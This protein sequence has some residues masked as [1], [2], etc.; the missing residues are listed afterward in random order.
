MINAIRIFD[1]TAENLFAFDAVGNVLWPS[2]DDETQRIIRGA[3][4]RQ[5][6]EVSV[7]SEH[8]VTEFSLSRSSTGKV[9]CIS[10]GFALYGKLYAHLT[11]RG[12][13]SGVGEDIGNY[14]DVEVVVVHRQQLTAELLEALY[15]KDRISAPG[16]LVAVDERDCY[17][18]VLAH[19]VYA[20]PARLSEEPLRLFELYPISKYSP[21]PR[22]VSVTIL[23]NTSSRES[24]VDAVT[25]RADVMSVFSH[26]DGVDA[27]FGNNVT[28]CSASANMSRTVTSDAPYCARTR[29]CFRFHKSVADALKDPRLVSVER[30]GARVLVLAVCAGALTS[31]SPIEFSWGFLPLVSRLTNVGAIATPWRIFVGHPSVLRKALDMLY[32]GGSIGEATER[33]NKS[34]HA[35]STGFR[36]AIF[37]DPR[38][39]GVLSPTDRSTTE[40]EPIRNTSNDSVKLVRLDIRNFFMIKLA[41]MRHLQHCHPQL[42][43]QTELVISLCNRL[44]AALASGVSDK[45]LRGDAS[46][47]QKL[48][49]DLVLRTRL[50]HYWL[51]LAMDAG[52]FDGG[53]C[54][55]CNS[56]LQERRFTFPETAADGRYLHICP[57]CGVVADGQIGVHLVTVVVDAGWIVA[58]GLEM[59][60]RN[61][62]ATLQITSVNSQISQRHAWPKD[63]SGML[64]AK[65]E[66]PAIDPA[67]GP[68]NV[69][70]GVSEDFRILVI[71]QPIRE[72]DYLGLPANDLPK[73]AKAI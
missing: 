65:M 4:A 61:A 21:S 70:L 1:T 48:L 23:D 71:T 69:V 7:T 16:L 25:C 58:R 34:E 28:L 59:F 26:G 41:L 13:V 44:E 5:G 63:S 15:R 60:S 52:T 37:G 51:P 40:V 36:L 45:R 66:L 11:G 19:S 22:S 67:E 56:A 42:T 12:F 38:T 62:V 3:A 27:Y 57:S 68:H 46:V 31:R 29:H 30:L 17:L 20:Q 33:L 73:T 18:Q 54:S 64:A 47:V 35:K 55:D 49:L 72:S 2:T 50:N 32:D 8:T 53:N 24:I 6:L 10:D 43:Q 9:V 39:R 14:E